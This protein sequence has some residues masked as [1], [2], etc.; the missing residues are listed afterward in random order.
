M[1]AAMCVLLLWIPFAQANSGGHSRRQA[2]F[3]EGEIYSFCLHFEN[4]DWEVRIFLAVLH[5]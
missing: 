3:V 4:L 5:H 2:V 1:S